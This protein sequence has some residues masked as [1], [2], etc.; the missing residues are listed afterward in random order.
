MVKL[1]R[2]LVLLLVLMVLISCEEVVDID[3]NS[4]NP[5]FVVEGVIYQD[6]V[7]WVRLTRTTDYFETEEPEYVQDA[8]IVIRDG[9]IQEQ[10]TYTE[11]GIYIGDTI[12]GT[13]DRLYEMEINY[14]GVVYSARSYMPERTEIISVRYGKSNAQSP[15]NPQGE[16]VYSISCD[17]Y[18]DP[19]TE[20]FYMIRYLDNDKLVENSYYL[21][22]DNTD[23][24]GALERSDEGKIH[25]SESV[26]YEGGE[27]E[28][29]LLTIDEPVYNYF[30]QLNDVLFWKRRVI[31][32]TPYNPQSNISNGALGYFAAWTLDSD[33][34]LLE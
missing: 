15:L 16:T 2:I 20:D 5:R 23:D 9:S 18:E 21:L 1:I 8:V 10:L 30:L 13:K 4:S 3:L 12:I 27:V 34:L 33:T 32:P 22:H 17:F 31:P 19:L 6:S 24:E 29:Q 28:I 26:F 14:D 25:F 11:N 7:S